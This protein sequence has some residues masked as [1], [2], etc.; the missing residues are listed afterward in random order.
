MP[1]RVIS[2]NTSTDTPYK[3]VRLRLCI[4]CYQTSNFKHKLGAPEI[5]KRMTSRPVD[6]DGR[7]P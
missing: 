1:K 7:I 5:T 6:A 3:S 2:S 4:L